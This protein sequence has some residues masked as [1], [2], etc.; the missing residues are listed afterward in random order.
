MSDPAIEAAQRAWDAMPT[1]DKSSRKA[2]G[3]TA[4]R[5]ALKP[6]R[7]WFGWW[8][9]Y[10]VLPEQAWSEIAPLIFTSVELKRMKPPSN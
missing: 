5:E 2:I 7:T 10:T 1:G 6:I 3:E 8:N 9:D 4:A